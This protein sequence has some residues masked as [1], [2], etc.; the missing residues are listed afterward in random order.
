MASL[1]FLLDVSGSGVKNFEILRITYTIH[2]Y[3]RKDNMSFLYIEVPFRLTVVFAVVVMFSQVFVPVSDAALP[4]VGSCTFMEYYCDGL[5][6]N[7]LFYQR[8]QND[9]KGDCRLVNYNCPWVVTSF[10]I[11]TKSMR[12]L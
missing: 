11:I 2:Y 10:Y 9:P 8:L 7:T 6:C 1:I 3:T 5:K 12:A 4:N